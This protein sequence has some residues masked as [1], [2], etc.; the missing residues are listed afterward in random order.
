M[1]QKYENPNAHSIL[2]YSLHNELKSHL[3]IIGCSNKE[4]I[5]YDVNYNKEISSTFD[6]E[7]SQVSSG[8]SDLHDKAIH[9][10]EF[11]KGNNREDPNCYNLFTTSSTDNYIRVWDIRSWQPVREFWSH[12]NRGNPIGWG[13]SNCLR[14]LITGSEDRAV[15]IYDLGQGKLIE[16]TKNS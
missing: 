3:C 5:V 8:F 4:L 1:V 16:K 13:I 14:Y 15:Y 2:S 6:T 12:V 11:F 10:L 9:T 7:G